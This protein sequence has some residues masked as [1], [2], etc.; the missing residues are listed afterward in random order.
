METVRLP[1]TYD[2]SALRPRI[3]H[4]GFGAF[5]RAHPLVY[6]DGA[7]G[8][9]GVAQDWGV[10]A[11]RLN[12]GVGDLTA[13]DAADGLYTVLEADGDSVTARQIGAVVATCHPARDGH[14]ALLALF[15]LPSMSIVSLT[16]TEKGYCLSGTSLDRN[17]PAIRAD[18][19]D[20]GAP[21]TAIGVIVEG[22]S[23][24]RAAGLG[25]LTVLSCDN[26][27]ENGRLARAAVLQ[28]ARARD[29]D[30]AIWI[31]AH[32]T[33]PAT[34]VDRIVPALDAEGRELITRMTGEPDPN[35]IV[36]EP[37]RQW[38]IED[39]FAAGRPAW[40]KAGAQLVS[41]VR[42]YEEMKL[43]ML[44]GAHTFLATLG[45]LAGHAKI[46]DCMGDP[47]FRRAAR[48]LMLSEQA[49]TLAQLPGVD[50]PTYADALLA[51]FSNSRLNH[52]TTQIA[53]DTSAKLPQ[54][55]LAPARVHLDAGKGWPLLSLCIAGWMAYV[56]EAA[57]DATALP[58]S[59]PLAER[60]RD[61]ATTKDAD[62]Y[63]RRMLALREVFP[64]DL[65]KRGPFCDAV[66]GAYARITA[67]GARAAVQE[68]LR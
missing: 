35:G 7:I 20:P 55:I 39:D 22:L 63:L 23:R 13:L 8:V 36:C 10:V 21:R 51:R 50:L 58:L 68:R 52:R 60:L 18:L 15:A 5:A 31:E 14:D 67:V 42:P 6:L 44:N 59:D 3:L 62:I 33:F 66:G 34:M 48:Q 4:L 64:E 32:V 43:R 41:D 49:P 2:R 9:G 54:R 53:T 47:V 26:L 19:A 40:E 37:F 65:A 27:P 45:A 17:H 57:V 16:I 56:R 25:G 46:A 11:V 30:L 29:A 1:P 12:S 61:I 28:F 24:R 38:V